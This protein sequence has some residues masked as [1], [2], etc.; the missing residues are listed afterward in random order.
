MKINWMIKTLLIVQI[1]LTV[2]VTMLYPCNLIYVKNDN[3]LLDYLANRT[4]TFWILTAQI[5]L[6]LISSNIR[7]YLQKDESANKYTT[8]HMLVIA[9]IFLIFGGLALY[10]YPYLGVAVFLGTTANGYSLYGIFR[11]IKKY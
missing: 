10:H 9:L 6:I 2:V 4:V 7:S 1:I 3:E 8:K 5:L 11:L